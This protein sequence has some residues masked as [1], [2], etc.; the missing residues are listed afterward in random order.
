MTRPSRYRSGPGVT[1]GQIVSGTSIGADAKGRQA[2]A[3][4]RP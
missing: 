1:G 3:R 2:K 4:H